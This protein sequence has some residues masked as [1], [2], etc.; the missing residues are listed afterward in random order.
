MLLISDH[1]FFNRSNRNVLKKIENPKCATENQKNPVK[2]LTTAIIKKFMFARAGKRRL[3]IPATVQKFCDGIKQSMVELKDNGYDEGFFEEASEHLQRAND[4]LLRLER[5]DDPNETYQ[6]RERVNV[7]RKKL[8]GELFRA[9]HTLKGLTAMV[10]LH[11]AAEL[12]HALETVLQAIQRG[13]IDAEHA[14]VGQLF[15]GTS[16]LAVEIES[17]RSP[18]HQ[19]PNLTV[20]IDA[21]NHLFH[22]AE[23]AQGTQSPAK[24]VAVDADGLPKV[25]ELLPGLSDYPE[26]LN[27][28]ADEDLFEVY[29]ALR[30]GKIF[31]V[32][33]F[34]PSAEREKSGENID[35]VR[36][37][38]QAAG[39]LIKV[40][41]RIGASGIQFLLLGF[42]EQF[43]AQEEWVADEVIRLTP[44]PQIPPEALRPER[45]P[46]SSRLYVRVDLEQLDDLM[47]FTGTLM[48][49]RYR[50]GERLDNLKQIS[51]AERR[52]ISQGYQQMGNTLRDL[53]RTII[54]ARL[55][56]LAEVVNRM[57]LVVRDVARRYHKEVRFEQI[58]EQ[59]EVD[60]RL[61]E[62]LFDPLMH[63]VRNAIGH[64][65]EEPAVR[66]AAG[67]PRQGKLTM[68]GITEG[69]HI[70][71]EVE[72]DGAGLDL[73][74]ISE[75][76]ARLGWI[77]A[78]Q[79]LSTDEALVII[80]RAGF[81]THEQ[82]D[83]TS[84]RGIGLDVVLSAVHA[85]GGQLHLLSVPGEGACFR[86]R[87]PM[88]LFVQDALLVAAGEERYAISIDAIE[89]VIEIET[90]Q[91]VQIPGG[92]L[93]PAKRRGADLRNGINGKSED[94]AEDSAGFYTLHRL[95][96]LLG[97][98]ARAA[99]G[100][101]SYGL[102]CRQQYT[103]GREQVVLQVD[104]LLGL[105]EVVVQTVND[106]FIAQP[107]IAGAAEL[108]D[109]QLAFI[110]D[111][112]VLLENT[113]K[114]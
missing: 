39:D 73:A 82:A 62:N 90:D 89:R 74:Q 2:L 98:T 59:V 35:K 85:M 50:L 84:G 88:R 37:Q 38:A 57:P 11:E 19:R 44:A 12:S 18:E 22:I 28:L 48:L 54:R 69:D 93:L 102:V 83:L 92:E 65:I 100:R 104:G 15:D 23:P 30:L 55:V 70:W 60:K 113:G 95:S 75:K 56:P 10:G 106:I 9:Y 16:T 114:S 94:E 97:T 87:L 25:R 6:D 40:V 32:A 61:V 3:I 76:A 63:L 8:L 91:I 66:E 99:N 4:C 43:P 20:E 17:Y 109:G 67:K 1:S 105:R 86:L 49:Q 13:Q 42:G 41:P 24:Q 107:G 21:L 78:G 5:L 26:L 96:Q 112:P 27:N 77:E 31:Y 64:G 51:P 72:D 29:E 14:V 103:R 68:R 53:R 71:V 111:L 81:S 34:S 79:T 45:A 7:E 52:E 80:T 110:L 101:R 47:R 33:L 108:P 36:E 46:E 58:G